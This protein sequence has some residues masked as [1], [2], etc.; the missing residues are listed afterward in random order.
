MEACKKTTEENGKPVDA[1]MD[2]A[3]GL[4]RYFVA[5]C[6]VESDIDEE[7]R[8]ALV[9]HEREYRQQYSDAM[10]AALSAFDDA[11]GKEAGHCALAQLDDAV[12]AVAAA[13]AQLAYQLGFVVALRLTGHT[14]EQIAGIATCLNIGRGTIGEDYATQI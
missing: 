11:P 4:D 6:D 5:M 7:T 1:I 10:K 9:P 14:P 2:L 12:D 13:E 8:A 3:A